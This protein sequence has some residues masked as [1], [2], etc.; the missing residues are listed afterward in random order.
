MCVETCPAA[1]AP[2]S[3]SRRFETSGRTTPYHAASLPRTREH[4][5]GLH[6]L[7]D[8]QAGAAKAGAAALLILRPRAL[9]TGPREGQRKEPLA[10]AFRPVPR[11]YR[12]SRS[13][14]L[15]GRV[16]RGVPQR[17]PSCCRSGRSTARRRQETPQV[18]GAA[19][20]DAAR[21]ELEPHG[22]FFR[23]KVC[24]RNANVNHNK[25]KVSCH[26]TGVRAV[27]ARSLDAGPK[28]HRQ[29]S[30][31]GKIAGPAQNRRFARRKRATCVAAG[32]FF[33]GRT[34]L[35]GSYN[36]PLFWPLTNHT[37]KIFL[38]KKARVETPAV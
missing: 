30:R 19:V 7:K 3:R 36:P 11:V 17:P 21:Q 29:S 4:R 27:G 26:I 13:A 35:V 38:G 6:V 18:K 14:T 23:K 25:T 9:E 20:G 15:A 34:R 24:H 2:C 12:G 37:D 33:L 22:R 10:A 16:A 5:R 28:L 1:V 31:T 8:R 32:T